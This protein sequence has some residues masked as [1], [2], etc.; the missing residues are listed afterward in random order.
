[1]A[2][3][4]SSGHACPKLCYSLHPSKSHALS[5]SY[6]SLPLLCP[7]YS[8]PTVFCSACPLHHS[9]HPALPPT[10]LFL[11]CLARNHPADSCEW[12]GSVCVSLCTLSQ[13]SVCVE[14]KRSRRRKRQWVKDVSQV[15]AYRYASSLLNW[16]LTEPGP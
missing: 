11:P 14:R 3:Y 1:M 16:V 4:P 2:Q 12:D 6:S 10:W 8:R 15:P 9:V 7:G 5:L 13:F